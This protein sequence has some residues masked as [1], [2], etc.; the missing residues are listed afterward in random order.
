MDEEEVYGKKHKKEKEDKIKMERIKQRKKERRLSGYLKVLY[1]RIRLPLTLLNCDR[2]MT[3]ETSGNV[4]QSSSL[5]NK[6]HLKGLRLFGSCILVTERG[7][8]VSS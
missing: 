1:Q 4:T 2:M 7:R 3:R 6:Y 5:C 8:Q